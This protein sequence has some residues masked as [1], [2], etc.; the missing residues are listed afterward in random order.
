MKSKEQVTL[1]VHLITG[2]TFVIVVPYWKAESFYNGWID[3][4]VDDS[5]DMHGIGTSKAKF[6]TETNSIISISIGVE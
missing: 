6:M 5:N 4:K 1:T 2:K 3:S